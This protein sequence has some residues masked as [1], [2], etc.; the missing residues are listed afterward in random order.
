MPNLSSFLTFIFGILCTILVL[1]A[2]RM[3]YRCYQ[4][5]K[6]MAE[7]EKNSDSKSTSSIPRKEY[8]LKKKNRERIMKNRQTPSG[9]GD[10][11][12]G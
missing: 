6:I 12:F 11:G 9:T 8:N 4:R 2:L 7:I 10:I 5:R 1:G 3:L